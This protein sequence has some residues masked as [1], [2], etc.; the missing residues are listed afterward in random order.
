MKY[1][2]SDLWGS[3]GEGAQFGDGHSSSHPQVAADIESKSVPDDPHFLISDGALDPIDP[4]SI[5][6][7]LLDLRA[8]SQFV[9]HLRRGIRC[10]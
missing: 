1:L 9:Q 4:K 3:E 10:P 5:A 6:Q 7:V 8:I 2:E